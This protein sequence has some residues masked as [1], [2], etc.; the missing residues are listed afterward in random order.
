MKSKIS[1]VF[2]MLFVLILGACSSNQGAS[3]SNSGDEGKKDENNFPN[4]PIS[5]IVAYDAGGGTDTT[6][7]TLAPFIEEELGVPVNIVNKPGGSGWVG[8]TEL[9]NSKP[10]GYTLGFL[11]SPNIAGG[12][13]N[14]SVERTVDLESFDMLGNHVVDP[15][16]I[17]IRADEERFTNLEELIDFA[18]SK[19]LT[20]NGSGVASDEHLVS[21]ILND[22]LETKFET[23]QFEGTANSLSAFLGGH[24]DVL[25]TSAGEA[26]NLHNSGEI[27]VI[28]VTAKERSTFLPDVPTFEEQGF[29]DVNSQV[30][31]GL[32]APKGLDP[33]IAKTLE[34]AIEKAIKNEEHVKKM[35]EIGTQVGYLN[36]EEYKNLLEQDLA[37]ITNVKDLLGW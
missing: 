21:L 3:S 6:A 22:K 12:L 15:G 1:L 23:V 11:N 32:A 20:T 16:V 14:P 7:R 10:D 28:G 33:E 27:K 19:K 18:K 31:R 34:S 36:G 8:W 5:I 17:A 37:D 30:T 2:I 4:K 25:V 26:Y 13:A 29:K 9:G 24:I 35:E